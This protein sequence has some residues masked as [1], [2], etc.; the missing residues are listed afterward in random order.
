MELTHLRYFVAVAEELH[1]GHAARELHITQPPLSKQIKRLEEELE[2]KLFNR[3]SRRVELTEAGIFFFKE[4]KAIL[5]RADY[6][7]G[8][9][10]DIAKGSSGSLSLGFNESAI[11]TFLPGT[12]RKFREK[13]PEVKLILHELE[14]AVQFE[15]LHSAQIDLGIM[16]PFGHDLSRL[17]TRLL[18]QE[19]YVVA[20]PDNHKFIKDKRQEISLSELSSDKFITLPREIHQNLYDHIVKCCEAV[21]FTPQIVQNAITKKTILALV[22]AGLGIALVQ[23]SAKRNAPERVGFIN[24]KRS[25]PSIDI[26]AVWRQSENSVIISNF[27]DVIQS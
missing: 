21:G 18:F 25:L 11:N 12:I 17:N 14:T 9:M 15:A 1:F 23:E 8:K 26:M 24:L 13:Y 2:V 10:R 5:A 19:K 7:S 20:V 16:R 27:L 4:A 6:V 22:E 3:T